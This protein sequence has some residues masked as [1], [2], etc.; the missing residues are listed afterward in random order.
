MILLNNNAGRA[1]TARILMI[2]QFALSMLV[3][4]STVQQNAL[5][6]S[7]ESGDFDYD[8][9]LMKD[10]LHT[11]LGLLFT[12]F[13][14]INIVFFIMWF[15]RAYYNLHQIPDSFPNDSE[16]WAA[17]AWFVPFLNLVK[18]FTIMKEIWQGTQRFSKS[19]KPEQNTT[20]LGFW[21][22]AFL[23]GNIVENIGTR[24]N[25]WGDE[26]IENMYLG[27]QVSIAGMLIHIPAYILIILIIKRVSEFEKDLYDNNKET[28]ISAHLIDDQANRF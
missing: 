16:G 1:K 26:S 20:I 7:I 11:V 21:W 6:G 3:L 5:L 28:D 4:L 19:G 25:L 14:I 17:G 9:I 8:D 10:Q 27:N 23:I 12:V 15:R 13:Y 18:P 22:A 2:V 24:I